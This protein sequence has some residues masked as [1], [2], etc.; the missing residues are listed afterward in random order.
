MPIIKVLG[1]SSFEVETGK[2]LVLALEE[3]D[4]HILHRCGGHAKCTTCR[5]EILA[6]DFNDLRNR[7]TNDFSDTL[8]HFLV[9]DNFRLSCQVEVTDNL[10][11]LPIMTVENTGIDAGPRPEEN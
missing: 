4:V 11:V 9:D 3:N 7:G 5:V 10:T 2:K 1:H 8:E 6:G